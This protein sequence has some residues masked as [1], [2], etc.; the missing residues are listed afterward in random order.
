MPPL[1]LACATASCAPLSAGVPSAA[2]APERGRV[3]PSLSVLPEAP[4]DGAPARMQSRPVWPSGP[5]RGDVG[6]PSGY[7]TSS[8]PGDPSLPWTC[9]GAPGGLRGAGG[10]GAGGGAHEKAAQE[11]GSDGAQVAAEAMPYHTHRRTDCNIDAARP[12]MAA[13]RGFA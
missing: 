6:Q 9:L 13:E 10:D 2:A 5:S 3:T 7:H 12:G 1:A 4:P 11:P 8:V